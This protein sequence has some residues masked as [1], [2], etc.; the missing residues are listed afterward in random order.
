MG[1]KSTVHP[2]RGDELRA[3][4]KLHR[5]TNG[6][7][8]IFMTERGGPTTAD[9]LNRLVKRLGNGSKLFEICWQRAGSSER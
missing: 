9:A 7:K 2:I 8:F 5:E 6:G 4:R 1:G 3:L